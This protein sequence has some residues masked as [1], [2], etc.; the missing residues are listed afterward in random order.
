V[1]V[2]VVV[3]RLAADRRDH[4]ERQAAAGRQRDLRDPAR[5]VAFTQARAHHRHRRDVHVHGRVHGTLD[6][7]H[8]FVGLAVAH[9]HDGADEREAGAGVHAAYR[10]PLEARER[11]PVLVAVGR[12]VVHRAAA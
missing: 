5:D 11:Q 9:V 7:G 12:K 10:H 6:L 4:R 3:Q 1:A 2:V 8:L